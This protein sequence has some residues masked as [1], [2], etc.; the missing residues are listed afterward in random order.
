MRRHGGLW[1][2][3]VSYPNLFRAVRRARR[4][5]T[6]RPDVLAFEFHRERELC[7]LRRE[8]QE[9]TYTPCFRSTIRAV[10]LGVI[11][12]RWLPSQNTS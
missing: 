2:R 4:G 10:P 1:E 8:L 12:T 9:R 6:G 11:Q 5:K 7:R 3:L